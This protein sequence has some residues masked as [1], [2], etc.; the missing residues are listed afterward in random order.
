MPAPVGP[1]ASPEAPAAGRGGY[2][3]ATL[4]ALATV[5]GSLALSMLLGLKACPLCFYQRTFAM[6]A[7]G[8]L[9]LGGLVPGAGARPTALATALLCAAGGLGVA[10]F[11]VFLEARGTLE[12]PAGLF[13]LGSAPTQSLGALLLLC[14]VLVPPTLR[15]PARRAGV[16]ALALGALFAVA[17][18]ASAPPLPPAPDAPYDGAPVV[19]RPPYAP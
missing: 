11:H 7:L 15:A 13:G 17:S 12:C 5:L 16:V 1:A 8:A 14:A 10:L 19:C 9:L 18:V 6:A 3:L 2:A 4:V